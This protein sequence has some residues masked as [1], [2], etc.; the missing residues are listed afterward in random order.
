MGGIEEV[1]EWE[2]DN[3]RGKNLRK[4]VADDALAVC[5]G[6]G[7]RRA[8]WTPSSDAERWPRVPAP[9]DFAVSTLHRHYAPVPF[10]L[11]S[12][13]VVSLVI[14]DIGSTPITAN[15]LAITRTRLLRRVSSPGREDRG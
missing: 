5:L 3:G 1:G 2:R 4:T 11:L 13:P 9:N 14:Q 8:F 15:I 7:K 10:V 12:P 6:V